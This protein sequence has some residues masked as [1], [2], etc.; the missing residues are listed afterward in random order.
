MKISKLNEEI[1][2]KKK[3][4]Y[5]LGWFHPNKGKYEVLLTH[6]RVLNQREFEKLVGTSIGKAIKHTIEAGRYATLDELIS[7]AVEILKTRGFVAAE[8]RSLIFE[9]SLRNRLEE[10]MDPK[11][12]DILPPELLEKLV[13]HN[14][15]LWEGMCEI[16][17]AKN[18]EEDRH[19]E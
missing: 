19:G 11:L 9:L 10:W 6:K 17:E 3:V 1:E 7:Q 13:E 4:V 12:R 5:R 14:T 18:S 8:V 15:R 2:T 16:E